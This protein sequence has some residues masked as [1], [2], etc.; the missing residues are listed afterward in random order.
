MDS[1]HTNIVYSRIRISRN[2]DE[3]VFPSKLTRSEREEMISRLKEGLK[4]MGEMNGHQYRCIQLDAMKDL[5]RRALRERRIINRAAVERTEPAAL[6][7]SE[8]ESSSVELGGDDHIRIQMLGTGMD[9]EEMWQKADA[10]DDFVN[11][12]FTYAFDEKYGYLTAFPTNLGTGLQASVV[13]HLPTLSM[14]RKFQSI[15]GD[16]SRFGAVIR[17]LYG[18]GSDNHGNLYEISNQRTLGLSEKEIV[19]LVMKAAAQLNNQET[20]VRNAALN[21]QRLEREDETWKSYG[22]LK[23]ARKISEK[24]ARIFLSQ[25]MAGEE[26]GLVSFGREYSMY[27]LIIG[28]QPANLNLWARRPLDKEEIDSVRAAYIRQNLPEIGK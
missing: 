19:D 25:L 16:M 12:S 24:D 18:E 14:I 23:Y 26:D 20:R 22:V 6:Y 10:I 28:C 11:E 7:L 3:Y 5:E 13:L 27:S 4:D 2:W 9:L 15:V 17:G 1:R 8:D 21:T